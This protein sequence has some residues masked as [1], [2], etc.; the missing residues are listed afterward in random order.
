MA[1]S[2]GKS[3]SSTRLTKLFH[4][5]A[6]SVNAKF[7]WVPGH[8]KISGNEEAD[9]EARAALRDLSERQTQPNYITLAY[10]RRLMQLHRQQLVEKWWSEVCPPRYQDL[11]LKMRRRKPPELTLSRRLLH[12]LKATRTGH[13]DFAAYHRRFKHLDAELKC[14]CGQEITPTYFIR[15]RRYAT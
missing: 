5:L 10:L 6:K 3:A 8:S 14:V 9:A 4:C 11:D 1:L 12:R 15:Y 7:R 2:T 13:G